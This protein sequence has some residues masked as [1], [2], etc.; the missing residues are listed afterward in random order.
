MIDLV[1]DGM[2]AV[3][4]VASVMLM[5]SGLLSKKSGDIPIGNILVVEKR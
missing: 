1:S 2:V 3:S 5:A 4:A